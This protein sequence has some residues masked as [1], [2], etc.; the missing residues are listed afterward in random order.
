MKSRLCRRAHAYDRGD[1][2]RDA[3]PIQNDMQRRAQNYMIRFHNKFLWE[4]RDESSGHI[5]RGINEL[6]VLNFF[7]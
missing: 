1:I 4:K 3:R 6:S 5:Y 2:T 7:S